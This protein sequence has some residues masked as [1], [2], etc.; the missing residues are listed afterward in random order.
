MITAFQR[1]ATLQLSEPE[2]ALHQVHKKYIQRF[3]TIF[4]NISCVFLNLKGEF[5]NVA[6]L[7][8]AEIT[9][10]FLDQINC[11]YY[12]PAIATDIK[13]LCHSFSCTDCFQDVNRTSTNIT[14][15]CF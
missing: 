10:Q 8:E 14:K 4:L 11:A 6:S 13:I 12:S 7:W 3:D 15:K 2:L 1:F 9:S 5:Y